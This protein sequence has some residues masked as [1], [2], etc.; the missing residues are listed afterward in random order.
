MKRTLY[1]VRL[2]DPSVSSGVVKAVVKECEACQTIDPAPVHWRKGKLNMRDN[3]N[4]LAM[5]IT[6]HG[7]KHFLTIIDCGPSRFAIWHPLRQQD[8]TSVVRQLEAI[9]Y[10]TGPA[11]RDI[12]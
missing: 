10:E 5:G 6:H 8:S 7:G 12:D 2:I 3:W 11:T 9:F 1:F 4:R